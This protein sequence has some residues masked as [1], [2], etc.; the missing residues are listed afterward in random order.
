MI[1]NLT[2]KTLSLHQYIAGSFLGFPTWYEFLPTNST[3]S[4][5][6]TGINDVWL[7]V[8]A[9]IDILLRIAAI[10]AIFVVIYGGIEFITSGGEPEKAASARSTVINALIGLVISVTAATLITFVAGRFNAS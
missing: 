9:V 10:I 6:F 2:L 3:G 8:A 7:I 1:N 5:A 4:P